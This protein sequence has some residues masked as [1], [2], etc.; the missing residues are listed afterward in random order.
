MR[1]YQHHIRLYVKEEL[2][3][4]VISIVYKTIDL[5]VPEGV[6][7]PVI[8]VTKGETDVF[9]HIKEGRHA[10]DMPT[11]RDL[12][13]DETEELFNALDYV[14]TID[15]DIEATTPLVGTLTNPEHDAIE[16][17]LDAYKKAV[18]QEHETSVTQNRS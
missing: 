5:I 6:L 17:G 14:M 18:K 16:V 1:S 13:P 15:F 9:Y 3:R 4:E 7:R 8:S 2:P 12:T 10:Y 11:T